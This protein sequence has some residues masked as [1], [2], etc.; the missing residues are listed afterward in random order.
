M[1]SDEDYK[2]L[3]ERLEKCGQQRAVALARE[4]QKAEERKM[5]EQQL[6][7]AGVDP[8]KTDEELARLQ[9]EIHHEFQQ[10]LKAVEQ[11]ELEFNAQFGE[12]NSNG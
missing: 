5:L 11:F 4:K 1:A 12:E 10:A 7:L 6:R 8:S 2:A 3:Q 9:R